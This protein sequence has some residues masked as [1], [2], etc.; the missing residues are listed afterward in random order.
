MIGQK[1]KIIAECDNL[2]GYDVSLSLYEHKSLLVEDNH[3]LT[4]IQDGKSVTEICAT[5]K[6][7]YAVAEIEFQE[8]DSSTY[9]NWDTKLNPIDG[10]LNISKLYIK[11]SCITMEHGGT[12][13]YFL[14][15]DK[16][17]FKLKGLIE[18]HI[19]HNGEISKEEY[20]QAQKVRFIYHDKIN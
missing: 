7:G 15:E 16:K 4:V 12:I 18:Q 2:N 9:K 8:V 5:V 13:K 14:K 1:I 6:D 10:S 19:Y 11:T 3:P 20:D 17:Y